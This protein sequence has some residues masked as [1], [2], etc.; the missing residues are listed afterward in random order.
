M[1]RGLSEFEP[2]TTTIDPN[3]TRD[4]LKRLY[5]YLVPDIIRHNLGEYYTP[6]WLAELVLDEV[7]YK[8]DTLKRLLDPACG[9]GTF[10]VLAVQRAKEYAR[11]NKE[12]LI[13][14]A[15]RITSNIWGFDLNPLVPFPVSEFRVV[16]VQNESTYNHK[17]F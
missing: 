2:A 10:L 4:L 14:T 16:R 1:A 8:G 11:G 6:D 7:G 12:P 15:K 13:E 3:S 17:I 5:Q 9:S